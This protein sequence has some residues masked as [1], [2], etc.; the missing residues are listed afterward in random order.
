MM[1]HDVVDIATTSP[2][3]S[4][5]PAPQERSMIARCPARLPPDFTIADAKSRISRLRFGRKRGRRE[6]TRI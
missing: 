4:Q 2:M 3:L 6:A 5:R 1:D